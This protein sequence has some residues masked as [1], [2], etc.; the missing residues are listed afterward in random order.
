[1]PDTNREV[2]ASTE[3]RCSKTNF[4]GIA[5]GISADGRLLIELHQG[6]NKTDTICLLHKH[7]ANV[8]EG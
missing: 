2:K 7:A 8:C 6:I 3:V 5:D 1:M 4:S